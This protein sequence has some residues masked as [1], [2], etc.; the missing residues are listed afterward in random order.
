MTIDERR[1]LL[2]LLQCYQ[3]IAL[4]VG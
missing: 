4:V 2:Q 1:G 3:R